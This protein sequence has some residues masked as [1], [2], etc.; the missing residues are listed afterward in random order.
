M[1]TK[2]IYEVTKKDLVEAMNEII[3]TEIKESVYQKFAGRTIN[4]NAACQVLG[5]SHNTLYIYIDEGRIAPVNVEGRN[6]KFLL[7]E[8][9]KADIKKF[10]K[11][12]SF[13]FKK[14]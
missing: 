11:G 6:H 5:I 14:L 13:K 4:S 8:L 9:L 2:I 12:S 10:S 7:S 3:S 1:E